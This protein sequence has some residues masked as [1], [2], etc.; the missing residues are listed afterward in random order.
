MTK[1]SFKPQ[2]GDW[3]VVERLMARWPLPDGRLG[4]H[5]TK[6]PV[7]ARYNPIIHSGLQTPLG[8]YLGDGDE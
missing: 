2:V 6:E 8:V 7:V 4:W 3:V 5:V 1:P